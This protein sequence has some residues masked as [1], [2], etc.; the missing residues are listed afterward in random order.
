MNRMKKCCIAPMIA[1]IATFG[2]A[3]AATSI[4]TATDGQMVITVPDTETYTLQEADQN[5]L[6]QRKLIKRGLGT[7]LINRALDTASGEITIEQGTLHTTKTKGLGA[8]Q[9]N[10][11]LTIGANAKLL[12]SGGAL[13]ELHN[14][15]VENNG[16]I[17]LRDAYWRFFDYTVCT[18]TG[19]LIVN[20]SASGSYNAVR[21][22]RHSGGVPWELVWNGGK[23]AS[24]NGGSAF[25]VSD[26][27]KDGRAKE[28]TW[29]GPVTLASD[30]IIWSSDNLMLTIEGKVSGTGDFDNRQ[31][32]LRLKNPA[33]DFTGVVKHV[34]KNSY[35]SNTGFAADYPAAFSSGRYSFNELA[36]LTGAEGFSH[37]YGLLGIPA[38]ATYG[39]DALWTEAAG[40][41]VIAANKYSACLMTFDGECATN[42]WTFNNLWLIHGGPG[43]TLVFT[44]ALQGATPRILNW[45][46]TLKIDSGT[47]CAGYTLVN[48]GSLQIAGTARFLAATNIFLGGIYPRLPRLEV[49][50]NAVLAAVERAEKTPSTI[51][52]ALNSFNIANEFKDFWDSLGYVN[53]KCV[54]GLIDVKG[55]GVVTNKIDLRCFGFHEASG[56]IY[57]RGRHFCNHSP[58]SSETYWAQDGCG[59][60]GIEKGTFENVGTGSSFNLGQ[61]VGSCST[62][63]MTGGAFKGAGGGAGVF[64]MSVLGGDSSFYMS[65]GSLTGFNDLQLGRFQKNNKSCMSVGDCYAFSIA[66]G[67]AVF[68]NAICFWGCTNSVHV[69]NLNGGT[70]SAGNLYRR[71]SHDWVAPGTHV[72]VNFNGGTL[73]LRAGSGSAFDVGGFDAVADRFTV[74]KGGAVL[75]S[76]ANQT[77]AQSLVAPSG[78]GI[79]SIPIPAVARKAWNYIGAPLLK[80]D[81]DGH[82]ASAVALFD[83]DN[84][85]VT[86]VVVT[87]PGCDYTYANVTWSYTGY[88]NREV[89]VATLGPNSGAGGLTKQGTGTLTLAAANAFGSPLRLEQGTLTCGADGAIPRE[90]DLVFAGGALNMGGRDYVAASVDATSGSMSV[91]T[92][93]VGDLKLDAAA[94]NHASGSALAVTGTV[95]FPLGATVVV[96]NESALKG[97]GMARS[98]A[99][100]SATGGIAGATPAVVDEAGTPINAWTCMLSP[101]NRTLSLRPT[102]GTIICFR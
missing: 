6:G 62:F 50:D 82:G 51:Y 43:G 96:R 74:Y 47:K 84:G 19:R 23:T 33:N 83:H 45:G 35:A 3:H 53:G 102:S 65:G 98:F 4:D 13:V 77:L 54:R 88:T 66:G 22:S 79:V 70:F 60:I 31:G 48:D 64:R 58:S 12:V 8:Q 11:K 63:V 87:S 99:L 95:V 93:T 36:V 44:G 101:D 34:A 46:G 21:L 59:Y 15:P 92:L 56:A 26:V 75:S 25:E 52:P 86:N 32:L 18:G 80:I 61:S 91:G 55:D 38:V 17:E 71:V 94:R 100:L 78:N 73:A 85:V 68:D 67:E 39:E 89:V 10:G 24:G 9:T 90:L 40:H 42:D 28:N 27:A 16:V 7:L 37:R 57:M 20:G 1:A 41:D 49:T 30:F 29:T 97:V 69:F 2:A 14:R 81:G 76:S 72:Y 5:A